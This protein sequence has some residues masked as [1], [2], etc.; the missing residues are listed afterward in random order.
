M[1]RQPPTPPSSAEA[2]DAATHWNEGELVIDLA[3][4]DTVVAMLNGLRPLAVQGLVNTFGRA[5][6]RAARR[7]LE[8]S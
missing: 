8:P 1:T 3:H 4:H 6:D 2:V 7:G 5:A